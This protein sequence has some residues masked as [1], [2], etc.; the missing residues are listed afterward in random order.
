MKA[1]GT[2]NL[3]GFSV[4]GFVLG[5]SA[6]QLLTAL[7]QPFPLSPN[8]LLVTMPVIGIGIYLASWPIYRYRKSVEG[9]E[10]GPR[11]SRPNPFYAVRVMLFS[12]ATALAGALFFG[13]HLGAAVWLVL[14]SV[15]PASLVGP[16]LFGVLGALAMLTGGLVGQWNC[17]TPKG[18]DGEERA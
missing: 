10:T 6:S 13:W 9:Y 17:R 3:F 12:R 1:I 5:L 16:T 2:G 15:S 7:G 4:I 14:F 18:G 11:P 8:S